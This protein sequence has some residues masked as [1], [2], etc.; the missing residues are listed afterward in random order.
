MDFNIPSLFLEAFGLKVAGS[1]Y[2]EISQGA[3]APQKGLYEGIKVVEDIN[4]AKEM[5]F[6][7]TPI[8]FP[9]TFMEGTYKKYN[10]RGEIIDVQ[11][12]EYRLPAAC[13][14]DFDR[15]KK[16]STTA[17][18]GGYDSVTE[19]YG[20]DNY[21]IN[22]N[23]FYLP[24]RTHP[25]GLITPLQQEQEM[26]KWDDL[27]CSINV[28]CELFSMRGISSITIKNAPVKALR[29]QPNI[30]PFSIQAISDA[31]IELIIKS[32]V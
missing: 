14:V 15:P 28:L 27:A 17:L 24:D 10:Y 22:I 20:F 12:A 21:Q 13:V 16:M 26:V 4:E 6:L 31:P 23:G 9:I 3:Q 7:G 2:P 11:M 30:R 19:I 25:Q 18:N 32:E 8:L 29:G 1:Y 5:S